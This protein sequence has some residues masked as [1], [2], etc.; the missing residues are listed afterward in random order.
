MRHDFDFF[1]VFNIILILLKNIYFF[2]I[3]LYI[4]VNQK[5]SRFSNKR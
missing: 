1:N 2:T 4:N 5:N 3:K